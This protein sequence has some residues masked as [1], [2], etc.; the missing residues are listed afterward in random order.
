MPIGTVGPFGPRTQK[1]PGANLGLLVMVVVVP[2]DDGRVVHCWRCP[3]M[4]FIGDAV[5]KIVTADHDER[6]GEDDSAGGI[7]KRCHD[8]HGNADCPDHLNE[9]PVERELPTQIDDGDFDKDEP[10][11]AQRQEARQLISRQIAA[12]C[13]QPSADTG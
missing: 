4:I 9:D 6:D 3:L 12:A 13:M 10:N 2:V 8:K 7:D 11:A 5:E 1:G